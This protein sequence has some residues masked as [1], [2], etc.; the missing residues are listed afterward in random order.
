MYY[1]TPR[2]TTEKTYSVV[3][4]H[5]S[6][7][8]E[9]ERYIEDTL[10]TDWMN[11]LTRNQGTMVLPGRIG[12]INGEVYLTA[13]RLKQGDL[14]ENQFMA[15]IRGTYSPVKRNLVVSASYALSDENRYERGVRYIEVESGQGQ[16]ILVDGQYIPDADGNYIEVEEIHSTQAQVSKGEK[17]FQ[18]FYN[19]E[20]VY[21][22]LAANNTEDLLDSG[23]RT[24]L[25]LL[26][27]Y[28]DG[29]QPYLLRQLNYQ[30]E[31]KLMHYADYYLFNLSSSYNFESR[32]I[33]GSDFEKSES[34]IKGAMNEAA[35]GWRFIEEGSYFSYKHDSY[36]SSPDN[37]DGFMIQMNVIRIFTGGQING[38]S[39][40]R[41]A[42]DENS[43]R[44]R[45]YIIGVN[46]R[47]RLIAGGETSFK[48]EGYRQEIRSTG[49]ISYRLIDNK[50]G[51][52]GLVWSIRSDYKIKKDLRINISFSGRHSDD[53]KSRIT[54]RGEVIASF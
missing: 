38:W 12:D 18:L 39:A 27:Y 28:S 50:Y 22:K 31:A 6:A 35:G 44:S 13:R 48:L 8:I 33:G 47:L 11:I 24:L 43:A 52:K 16:Y 53:R 2:G 20:G 30:A 1:G 29:D 10:M 49:F 5:V 14:T 34:V 4:S 41:Y 40:Y 17:S 19:P 42:E 32:Q 7:R 45:Q 54:G 36:Y 23:K 3:Y 15:R 51:G 37:I 21:L 9:L 26:P 46:P 25:W